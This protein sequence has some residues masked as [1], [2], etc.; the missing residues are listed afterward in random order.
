[1]ATPVQNLATQTSTKII[2]HLYIKAI[3][4]LVDA[5]AAEMNDLIEAK[6]HMVIYSKEDADVSPLAPFVQSV[7]TFHY[8][9]GELKAWKEWREKGKATDEPVRYTEPLEASANLV[10]EGLPG[11]TIKFTAMFKFTVYHDVVKVSLNGYP[12]YDWGLNLGSRHYSVVE[13]YLSE[14]DLDALKANIALELTEPD[15]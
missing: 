8:R 14:L 5:L 13:K 9:I 12:S 7:L 15:A 10:I 6:K 3:N 11:G 1:M 2:E 4:P